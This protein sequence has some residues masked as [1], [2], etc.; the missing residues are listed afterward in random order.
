M[1]RRLYGALLG[2]GLGLLPP[3]VAIRWITGENPGFADDPT[4]LLGMLVA[5][6]LLGGLLIGLALRGP[7]WG[8]V[9]GVLLAAVAAML[10]GSALRTADREPV[11]QPLMLV[12]ALPSVTWEEARRLPSVAALAERGSFTRLTGLE[13][14][15]DDWVTLDSGINTQ[16]RPWLGDRPKADRVPVAR[17]WDVAAWSGLSVGLFDWPV[18]APVRPLPHGGFVVPPGLAPSAWP[19]PVE[20]MP[21]AVRNLLH[22]D[23][24][25]PGALATAAE[26]LP[27]GLRWSTLR[28]A[29]LYAAKRRWKAEAVDLLLDRPL[30]RARL[31]RDVFLR[32]LRDMRPDLG[33]VSLGAP[34]A[35][36]RGPARI[37]ALDQANQ[38]LAEILG[39]LGAETRVVLL[40]D[41]GW[42]V[43]SG[44]GVTPDGPLEHPVEDVAPTLLGLLELPS[45]RDMRGNMLFGGPDQRVETWD[46]LAPAPPED[47][48]RRA[49]AEEA[50]RQVGYWE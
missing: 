15:L 19:G 17:V 27:L 43:S 20:A 6:T 4:S 31:E 34:A 50:L 45:A 32:L 18:T 39:A 48:H 40:S 41:T 21:R 12:V 3:L 37:F 38:I 28:D 49:A 7:R 11:V 2:A 35:L 16:G 46:A 22:P 47:A 30:I 5:P 44:S 10:G 36:A 23:Q 14:G 24:A 42:M 13:G 1:R 29:G 26:L 33:A 8:A 25:S 9:L